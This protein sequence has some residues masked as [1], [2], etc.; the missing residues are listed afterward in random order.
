M[1]FSPVIKYTQN[2]STVVQFGIESTTLPVKWLI[3]KLTYLL[4]RYI[5]TFTYQIYNSDIK[6]KY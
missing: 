3:T 2:N 6:N 4:I 1:K 5:H